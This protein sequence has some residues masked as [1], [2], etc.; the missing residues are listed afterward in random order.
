MVFAFVL[1]SHAVCCTA[2]A[3][4]SLQVIRS[5]ILYQT[6]CILQVF[7]TLL[8]LFFEFTYFYLYDTI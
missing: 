6:F 2:C 4:K 5:L 8:T 7:F 1:L 3:H